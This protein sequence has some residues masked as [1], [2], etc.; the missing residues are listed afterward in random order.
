MIARLKPEAVK[1]AASEIRTARFQS[2][3]VSDEQLVE[4]V[5]SSYL[6][7]ARTPRTPRA[8]GAPRAA[9]VKR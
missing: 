3:S 9:A 4:R 5:V 8:A 7:H 2:H 1:R 6:E